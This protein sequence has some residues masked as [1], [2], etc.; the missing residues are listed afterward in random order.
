LREIPR[1]PPAPEPAATAPEGEE[2]E[3]ED[4]PDAVDAVEEYKGVAMLVWYDAFED[5]AKNLVPEYD[6]SKFP[7]FE[8]VVDE[9]SFEAAATCLGAATTAKAIADLASR[10]KVSIAGNKLDK[11][12]TLVLWKCGL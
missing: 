9:E 1:P 7:E 3:E 12:T 4:D 6:E 11:V 8:V 5:V 10:C 2:S